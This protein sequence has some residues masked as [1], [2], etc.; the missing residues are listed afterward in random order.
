MANSREPEDEADMEQSSMATSYTTW[1]HR[2]ISASTIFK[3]ESLVK[4]S[5]LIWLYTLA[6]MHT[7]N[8]FVALCLLL[9]FC[10]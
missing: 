8:H 9:G 5:C 3:D 7:K 6:T 1:C 4:R 2:I 10:S